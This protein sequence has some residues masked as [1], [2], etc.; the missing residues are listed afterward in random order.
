MRFLIQLI[1]CLH[2]WAPVSAWAQAENP[3]TLPLRDYGFILAAALLGG[4]VSWWAKVRKGDRAAMSIFGFIGEMVTS[5]F[6]GLL[7]FFACKYLSL[8]PWL[9][10]AIVGVAGHMGTRAITA[11]EALLQRKVDKMVATGPTPLGK[12]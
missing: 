6:A 4:A 5:A 1:L 12:E 7:A 11:G 8:S 2:L 10:A 3:L 9:T